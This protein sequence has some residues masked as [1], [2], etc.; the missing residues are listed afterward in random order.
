MISIFSLFQ[1][2]TPQSLLTT[3]LSILQ[4]LNQPVTSWRSGDP[5]ITDL[6]VYANQGASYSQQIATIVQGGFLDYAAQV[7]PD[8]SVTPGALPGWLDVIASS[9]FNLPNTQGGTGRIPALQAPVSMSFV[10]TGTA[11]G[12]FPPL[13]FHV[14]NPTTNQTYS[15]V[16]QFTIGAGTTAGVA[17][18]ADISGVS[19][20]STGPNTITALATPLIGVTCTNPLGAVGVNAESNTALVA[21][22]RSKMGSLSPNGPKLAYDFVSKTIPLPSPLVALASGSRTTPTR[23]VTRTKQVTN[24][25]TGVV[26]NFVAHAA[27]AYQSPDLYTGSA[28]EAITNVTNA[29]PAVITVPTHGYASVDNVYITGTGIAALDGQTFSITVLTGNT[30]SV[31]VASGA[32]ST[33]G[34]AYRVS[35]MDLIDKTV[36]T[37][38]VPLGITAINLSAPTLNVA[39]TGTIVLKRGSTLT[40]LAA[41]NAASAALSNYFAT[42]PL[43]GDNQGGGSFFFFIEPMQ[44]AVHN[45]MP[46]DFLKVTINGSDIPV[47]TPQ[48]VATLLSSTWTIVNEI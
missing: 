9:G 17:F 47:V 8:P 16:S 14:Y 39:T 15:N 43:G 28:N 25:A 19:G 24:L 44:N 3:L 37:Y 38:C 48:D 4:A 11:Q 29:N 45:A 27:G 1:P 26:S 20:G 5:S 41:Q 42:L 46:N 12:P 7:T 34:A 13:T 33:T 6:N 30:F 36:Q 32:T 23:P 10:N 22:C 21:R 35:D 18:I 2:D 31:P 40:N